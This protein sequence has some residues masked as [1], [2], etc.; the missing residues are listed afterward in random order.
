MATL[1]YLREALRQ[2]A[3]HIPL[4]SRQQLSDAQ[5]ADG[6]NILVSGRDQLT[7]Q[8]F[9]IPQLSQRLAHMFDT[10]DHISALE[11]V[12]APKKLLHYL[13]LSMRRKIQ[14]YTTVEPSSLIVAAR[15]EG[16]QTS[17]PG[18]EEFPL[19]AHINHL[20][21]SVFNDNNDKF[22]A[23]LFCHGF[24]GM[25]PR[26]E[27]IRRA[28]GLLANNDQLVDSL[29]IVFHG[30][31]T[32]SLGDL[33]SHHTA[34][35][36]T[37]IITIADEDDAIDSFARFVAGFSVQNLETESKVRLEWRQLCRALCRHEDGYPNQ[38]VFSAPLIMTVL[39]QHS[40]KLPELMRNLSYGSSISINDGRIVKNRE[41]RLYCPAKV[42]TPRHTK[43]VQACVRWATSYDLPL[44]VIGGGHSAPCLWPGTAAI[45]MSSLDTVTF[46]QDGRLVQVGGGCTTGEIIRET[47]ARGLTVP[48]GARPSVG[49]GLWL[50]GGIGHLSRL[51]GLTCDA[52]VGAVII[53]LGT[54]VAL[55]VGQVLEPPDGDYRHSYRDSILL[56]VLRGA[57]TNI[58]IVTSVTFKTHEASMCSVKNWVFRLS[59]D[60]EA[61]S[62]LSILSKHARSLPRNCSANMFLYWKENQ[63]HLG[64]SVYEFLT[65][66]LALEDGTTSPILNDLIKILGPEKSTTLVDSVGLFETDMYMSTM[67]SGHTG[68]KTSAF[69]R[70]VFLD[71]IGGEDVVEILLRALE[72]RPTPLCHLHL[73]QGG[74][75]I[76]DIAA[77][78]TAFGCR[79]WEYACVITGSWP[80]DQDESAV[81]REAVRWVYQVATDLLPLSRGTY[82]A[83]LGPDPRDVALAAR[84]FGRNKPRLTKLKHENDYHNVL[85]YACPIPGWSLTPKLM[86]LVTGESGA[87]KDYCAEAWASALRAEYYYKGYKIGAVSISKKSKREYA[88][89][90]GADPDRLLQNRAYEEKH[91]HA[92]NSFFLK[93]V[94]ERPS[95]PTDT[96]LE[97]VE[98]A[99]DLDVLFITGMR[100][101]AP[102]AHYGHLTPEYRVFE[103]RIKADG[104]LRQAPHGSHIDTPILDWRPDYEFVND[105]RGDEKAKTFAHRHLFRLLEGRFQELADMVCSVPDKSHEGLIFHHL[106]GIPQTPGGLTYSTELLQS[107]FCGD[108]ADI[109]AVIG[110]EAGGFIFA[111]PLAANLE[112]PLILIR[113]NKLPQPVLSVR[114]DLSHISSR[115]MNDE[116]RKVEVLCIEGVLLLKDASV[117]VVDDVLTSGTTLLALLQLLEKAGITSDRIHVMVIAEFPE[118]CARKMLYQKG[119]GK[120]RIQSLLVYGGHWGILMKETEGPS[121]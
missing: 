85:K 102:V 38:L 51:Y 47:S 76:K 11:W 97:V 24:Y 53:C 5:Y 29:V 59:D 118:Y 55:G 82:G 40:T 14:R 116:A 4:D 120:V 18:A 34:S 103:V 65:A 104:E 81:T 75:A 90:S 48:M 106:L 50:Q 80:R 119:F 42:I 56:W 91:R 107:H 57:G 3:A 46:S 95:L 67:N 1:S 71:D 99:K 22:D 31:N 58:G 117:V 13:P 113:N 111:S 92:M 33:V 19:A 21:N 70:C 35:F 77:H 36:P 2:Q 45:D 60:Q 10:R 64:V 101:H 115:E 16:S 121:S 66:G 17:P 78:D 112:R 68:G 98:A 27:H 37:S 52:I 114:K 87:G 12:P 105:T 108:W 26:H 72:T 41:A 96:F 62:K 30:D 49:A 86:I 94:E 61:K 23:I 100:V 88:A 39:T 43:G 25:K 69:T 15:K 6:F 74:G 110:C 79:D 54:G 32:S 7:Y 73:Q 44:T 93:Q 20:N 89:A 83:D 9:I 109:G 28:L 8:D 84:A 63:L